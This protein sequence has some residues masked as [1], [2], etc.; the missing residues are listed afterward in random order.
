MNEWENIEADL[1]WGWFRYC[2]LQRCE[3]GDRQ[4]MIEHCQKLRQEA[5]DNPH[6]GLFV[7]L[8]D[9][10]LEEMKT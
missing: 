9:Q 1:V 5:M 8:M 2:T 3:H 6:G 10:I 7:H 4:E